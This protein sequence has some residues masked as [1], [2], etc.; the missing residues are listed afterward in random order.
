[1]QRIM[2][3]L[4][5]D[6][7]NNP[8]NNSSTFVM[9]AHFKVPPRCHESKANGNSKKQQCE[10]S[11]DTEDKIFKKAQ[12]LAIPVNE[13]QYRLGQRSPPID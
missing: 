4:V 8:T 3:L 11:S 9:I 13:N 2:Y 10:P 1:M 12:K 6:P 7:N 5:Q